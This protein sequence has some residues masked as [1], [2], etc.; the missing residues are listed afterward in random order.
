MAEVVLTTDRTMMSNHHGKEFLGFG[1]TGVPLLMPE[2]MWMYL[3]APKIKNHNGLPA[4]APYGM[5]K[6]EAVL[7]DAGIDAKIVDP[8]HLKKHLSD[9]KVLMF[10]HHDY[11]GFG[12]PSSTFASLFQTDPLN[13]RSFCRLIESEEVREA[14]RRGAI[15]I[16][17]GPSAWQWKYREEERKK[18]GIDTVVEGEGEK[19]VVP[20]VKKAL[21]GEKLPEWVEAHPRRDAPDISEIPLIKAPSVNGL[22]EV[23]RGC[24]RGCKF[25]SVTLRPFRHIPLEKIEKEILVNVNGGVQDGV[26]LAEDVLLYGQESIYPRADRVLPLVEMAKRHYRRVVFSHMSIAAMVYSERKERLI[27]RITEV[28]LDENQKFWGA[29]IGVETGSP[30]LAE[31]IMP[32]KAKPF[33]T[34]E[35]PE[36]VL[37]AVGVMEDNNVIPAMTLIAGLP[38]ETEDDVL[39]TIELVEDLGDFR[40]LIVPLFFVPMGMLDDRD[41]FTR[42]K[43]SDVHM[44]LL[45]ACLTHGIKQAK[46]ILDIYLQGYWYGPILRGGLSFFLKR[47]ESAARKHG[48]LRENTAMH[49]KSS[50]GERRDGETR[51][52]GGEVGGEEMHGRDR[53]GAAAEA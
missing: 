33:K 22:V 47:V 15:F 20:L 2:K 14:K 53:E 31:K 1:A 43:M 21:E 27:S 38:E 17:G 5:R 41:W 12:P 11:F 49:R 48:Y 37:E 4:Q 18:W 50:I 42:Y 24:P 7:Q 39:R 13:A 46:N 16:A 10:S 32:A 8:A 45:R 51:Y 9:A 40:G 25:C 3:F 35:W 23:S 26:L 44:E 29:E 36:L 30:R 28:L 6:I 19:I 52:V 34:S